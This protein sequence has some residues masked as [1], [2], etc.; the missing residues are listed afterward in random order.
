MVSHTRIYLEHTEALIGQGRKKRLLSLLN[1]WWENIKGRNSFFIIII[2]K[3]SKQSLKQVENKHS[4]RQKIVSEGHLPAL[5]FIIKVSTPPSCTCP[6]HISSL[7]F[8]QDLNTIRDNKKLGVIQ[9]WY[10]PSCHYLFLPYKSLNKHSTWWTISHKQHQILKSGISFICQL[11][12]ATLWK[13]HIIVH[14]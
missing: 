5:Y 7:Q 12:A 14:I 1:Q 10:N 6:L 8:L 2:L 3:Y 9:K 13:Y 4:K 11:V